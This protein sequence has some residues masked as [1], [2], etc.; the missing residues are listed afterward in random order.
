MGK[1]QK[2]TDCINAAYSSIGWEMEKV[3]LDAINM[4]CLIRNIKTGDR[5]YSFNA[6]TRR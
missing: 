5:S 6:S 4:A 2:F 1:K 3:Y